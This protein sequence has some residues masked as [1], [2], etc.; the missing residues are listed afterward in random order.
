MYGGYVPTAPQLW[1]RKERNLDPQGAVEQELVAFVDSPF[2]R[3][4]EGRVWRERK[5]NSFYDES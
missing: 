3:E 1:S 4:L 2:I 5:F